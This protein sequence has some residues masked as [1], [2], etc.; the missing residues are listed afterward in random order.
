MTQAEKQRE[1]LQEA[2]REVLQDELLKLKKVM[3]NEMRQM[4]SSNKQ[5]LNEVR[6]QP[7]RNVNIYEEQPQNTSA[8]QSIQ[9]DSHSL[10]EGFMKADPM[11]LAGINNY[12]F[13]D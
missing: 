4:I 7:R 10:F 6:S 13:N 11:G 3:L 5:M 1:L 2:V 8:I 9:L 12:G